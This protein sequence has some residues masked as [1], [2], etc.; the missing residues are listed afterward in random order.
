MFSEPLLLL[1]F[2]VSQEALSLCNT[3]RFISFQS[4]ANDL[5][6]EIDRNRLG[7]SRAALWKSHQYGGAHLQPYLQ[8]TTFLAAVGG[9]T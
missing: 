4:L 2:T 7:P 5:R 3:D 9:A 8:L 6:P 1:T